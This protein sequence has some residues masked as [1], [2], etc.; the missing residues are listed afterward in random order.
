MSVGVPA[1]RFVSASVAAASLLLVPVAAAQPVFRAGVDLV[2]IGVTVT[3]RKGTLITDLGPGDFEIVERGQ[4]QRIELF[5]HG[6][7][8]GDARPP[9]HIGLLFD[10]SG[11]MVE[12]LSFA[13]SAAIKFL[14]TVDWADDMTLVDFDTEVRVTRF[15]HADFPRLVE[16]VRS[17]KSDGWTALYDAVGIYLDGASAVNGEKILVLY[18]DGGNNTSSMSFGDVLTALKASDVTLYVVGL[19]EHQSSS[20]RNEL[21]LRLQQLAETAGGLAFFPMSVKQL[22]EMYEKIRQEIDARYLLGYTSTD[23][24]QDGAWRSVDVRL[25]RPDLK[26]ARVRARKGYYAPYKASESRP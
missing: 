25:T 7:D 24:R 1:G 19:L 11:S 17:R 9:L 14:K 26:G 12:D 6:S 16:R 4:R 22:D 2:H 18:T 3:D 20:W 13:Q 15:G 10:T 5:A 23:A 21:R 8:R